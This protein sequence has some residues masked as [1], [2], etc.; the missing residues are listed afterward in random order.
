MTDS[1]I[2]AGD[3]LWEP[4]G[5]GRKAANLSCFQAW[6][7]SE[8]GLLF[9][10]YHDLWAWSSDRIEAFWEA[11]WEY[12][13]IE[14]LEPYRQVLTDRAMP[15][16]RWFEGAQ[17]NYA[18]HVFR[19]STPDRPALKF[20]SEVH[21]LRA[22]TWQELHDQ[23]SATASFLRRIGV[24]P[25]DR[26][27]AYLPNIPETVVIFLACASVG[28]VWSCCSPD[29]AGRSV[30]DRFSQIEPKVLFGVDEYVYGGRTFDCGPTVASLQRNLPTLEQ[31][32]VVPYRKSPGDRAGVSGAVTWREIM[33]ER[34]PLVFASLPFSHPL[35]VVYSSGTT[36]K[37]KGLVHSQ[38]G[39]LLEFLKFLTLHLN[40]NPGDIFFWYST[41]GWV[42]WNIVQGGLLTGAVPLL[43]DGNP[44][45]P[46]LYTL[47]ETAEEAQVNF[48]GTS[49]A[50][51]T[52]CQQANLQPGERFNLQGIRAVGSTGSPPVARGVQ[53]DIRSCESGPGTGINCGRYR[54]VHR[55]H[56]GVPPAAGA[57]RR[58]P[59]PV[60]GSKCPG[61]G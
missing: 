18:E 61:L 28:A 9:D 44:A 1:G 16:G 38:G 11:I 29:F 48:F 51:I 40:L 36:G 22:V 55:F 6:L 42:M 20:R 21:P 54:C 34:K 41:T 58:T 45:Y 53:V 35:W 7:K 25:G 30:L 19:R 14:T 23:V 15:G 39:I 57:G 37:P 43:F 60:P 56:G 5:A 12:F 47:W 2:K 31:V 46:D 24:G 32:V 49:A 50:F 27:V 26:V 3:I 8:K 59:V 10:D 4:T 33:D 13:E 52:A 17:L